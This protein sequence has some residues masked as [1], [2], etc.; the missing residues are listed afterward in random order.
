MGGSLLS[1]QVLFQGVRQQMRKMRPPQIIVLVFLVLVLAGAGLLC[2]PAASRFGEPTSFLTSLFTA[3][4]AT[5]VTGLIRVDTGSYWS[6][7]GQA[8]ILLLI[9]I[10]G[11]GFMTVAS[12]FFFALRRKIGLRQRLVI[13]QAL[14][15]DQISG[16]VGLVRNVLLG[17]LAVE[18]VGALILMLRFWPVYGFG[19]AVW[20]GI[21]H[22]VSAYCNAGFDVLGELSYGGSVCRYVDDPVVNL[23]LMALIVIGGLGFA[24]WGDLRKN[25]KFSRL[26]VYSRLVVSISLGLIVGG[27]ALIALLEWNNPGT[28]GSLSAGGKL[29]AATFQSVTLRTAGFASFDQNAMRDVTKALCDVL[30]FIG[31][32]SG[33]TAGGVKTVTVGVLV[34]AAI[35]TARGRSHVTAFKRSIAASAVSN[36]AAVALL[37]LLLGAC[38]A[39]AL[40][41]ID[42]VSFDNAIFETLSAL[43]TVGLTTGITATLSTASCLILI[44]FM[45]FGRVGIM[46]ISVGFMM[47]N[48][49][50]ERIAY[51]QTR[52]MI[53]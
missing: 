10:G 27:A 12:I 26:S 38:G 42:G 6:P 53:G 44:V 45:F 2:L 33:S 20:Y 48:R 49:A 36:A 39:G 37:V 40:S 16:V 3:T 28:I 9:Q 21:F 43:C 5:C 4:S 31:G 7:F 23:T 14:S 13:A 32:S 30:M 25:R 11:L 51:A 29:L 17:T 1:L 34:L 22:A 47:A 15:L 46:T 19:R 35:G 18:G 8:V 41:V 52:V 50:E 24:V